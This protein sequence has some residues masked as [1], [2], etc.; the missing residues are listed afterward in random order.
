MPEVTG[1]S[2]FYYSALPF[3]KRLGDVFTHRA[4]ALRPTDPELSWPYRAGLLVPVMT[5]RRII[6]TF[7]AF[8]KPG[9]KFFLETIKIEKSERSA[10]KSLTKA[11][12]TGI[13]ET[14]RERETEGGA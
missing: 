5:F 9:G 13:I 7:S 4:H 2:V 6:P 12:K 3:A 10:Q 1:A 8:V 11:R 14:T